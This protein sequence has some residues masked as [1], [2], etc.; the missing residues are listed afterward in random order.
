M[1][2][3][4]SAVASISLSSL[5]P[6]LRARAIWLPNRKV[7]CIIG[8]L[9]SAQVV[10]WA[11]CSDLSW[12]SAITTL[13]MLCNNAVLRYLPTSS[14]A[15]ISECNTYSSAPRALALGVW[16]YSTYNRDVWK[17]KSAYLLCTAMTFD[18]VILA[19]SFMRLHAH[20][21]GRLGGLLLR[22]GTVR[23]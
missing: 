13:T 21:Q 1:T 7:E 8:L 3:Q 9:W 23:S 15:A 12:S 11:Q 19:L 16:T 22:D 2:L 5:I 14:F 6:A 17:I 10:L 20:R 18:V 4:A